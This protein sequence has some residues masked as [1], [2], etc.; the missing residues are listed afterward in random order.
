MWKKLLLVAIDEAG[1][2]WS[3][4]A[5]DEVPTNMALMAFS[6]SEDKVPIK[7]TSMISDGDKGNKSEVWETFAPLTT[8]QITIPG[9]QVLQLTGRTLMN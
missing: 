6:D 8:K 5:D 4:M 2:D 9:L 3:Y 1:F 7:G